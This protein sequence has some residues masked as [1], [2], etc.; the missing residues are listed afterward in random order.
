MSDQINRPGNN[1]RRKLPPSEHQ[2]QGE[3]A[4]P[5]PGTSA[6]PGGEMGSND[7]KRAGP[8]DREP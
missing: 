4:K 3:A 1:G 7:P 8:G 6:K 2:K 5:E